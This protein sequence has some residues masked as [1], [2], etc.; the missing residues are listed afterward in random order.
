MIYRCVRLTEDRY[1]VKEP[2]RNVLKSQF[3]AITITI[4]H[5]K[6]IIANILVRRLL[7]CAYIIIQQTAKVMKRT[8]CI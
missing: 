8:Q 6:S 3:V 2:V 1:E 5:L 7:T 4:K